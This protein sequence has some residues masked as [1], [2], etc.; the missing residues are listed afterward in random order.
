MTNGLKLFEC[1]LCSFESGHEDCRKE[2]LLYH[3]N[4]PSYASEKEKR[5]NAKKEALKSMNL[6]DLYDDEGKTPVRQHR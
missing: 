6:L 5:S 2:H 1:N 4:L 3:V